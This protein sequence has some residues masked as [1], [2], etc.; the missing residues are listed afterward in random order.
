MTPRMFEVEMAIRMMALL[1][2][3]AF[4]LMAIYAWT[5][6]V[7]ARRFWCRGKKR[8]VLVRFISSPFYKKYIDVQS[9]SAFKKGEPIDCGKSCLDY[10]KVEEGST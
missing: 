3:L 6:E 1:G 4:L 10:P 9:C 7:V 8:F 5:H 2:M